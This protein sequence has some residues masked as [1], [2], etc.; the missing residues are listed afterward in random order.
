MFTKIS[1]VSQFQVLRYLPGIKHGLLENTQFSSTI[2]HVNV[3]LEKYIEMLCFET[4]YIY[5]YI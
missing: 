4:I 3:H 2:S 5:I 1:V